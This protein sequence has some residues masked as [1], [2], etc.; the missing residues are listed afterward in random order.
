MKY[1]A[2]VPCWTP[3][4]ACDSRR[5]VIGVAEEE[6]RVV[7]GAVGQ[8]PNQGSDLGFPFLQPPREINLP[9]RD[10]RGGRIL[11]QHGYGGGRGCCRRAQLFLFSEAPFNVVKPLPLAVNESTV[12]SGGS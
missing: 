10:G 6:A 8:E 2:P 9:F 7:G 4:A 1:Q 5:G 12:D 3:R 11:P